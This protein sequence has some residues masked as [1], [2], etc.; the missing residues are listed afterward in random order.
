[1]AQAVRVFGDDMRLRTIIDSLNEHMFDGEGGDD[2]E[3]ANKNAP[4]PPAPH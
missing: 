1:V 2:A 3:P 4:Q